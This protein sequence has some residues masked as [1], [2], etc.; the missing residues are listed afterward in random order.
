LI[1]HELRTK[2][3]Q[4]MNQMRQAEFVSSQKD[5]ELMTMRRHLEGAQRD[6]KSLAWLESQIKQEL[7]QVTKKRVDTED[8]C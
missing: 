6:M 2:N 1:E 8:A 4:V 3:E 7:Q 5:E